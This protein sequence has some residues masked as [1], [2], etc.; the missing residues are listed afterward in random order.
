MRGSPSGSRASS[1]RVRSQTSPTSSYYRQNTDP[2]GKPYFNKY[3]HPTINGQTPQEKREEMHNKSLRNLANSRNL[4]EQQLE[5]YQQTFLEQQQQNLRDFN[6]QIMKEI[7]DDNAANVNGAEFDRSESLSSL[8]SL[9]EGSHDT[10][11]ESCDLD[12]FMNQKQGN[13]SG[14]QG[15][16]NVSFADSERDSVRTAAPAH[17][18]AVPSTV[19][20][21]TPKNIDSFNAQIQTAVTNTVKSDEQK[22]QFYLQRQREIQE[23]LHEQKLQQQR[24][25]QDLQQKVLEQ[26]RKQQ[27][28]LQQ[29]YEKQQQEQLEK[30]RQVQLQPQQENSNDTGK[31]NYR[32]KAQMKAW[33]TPSPHPPTPASVVQTTAHVTHASPYSGK[34]THTNMTVPIYD[35]PLTNTESV[36]SSKPSVSAGASSVVTCTNNNAQTSHSRTEGYVQPEIKQSEHSVVGAQERNLSFLEAVTNDLSMKQESHSVSKTSNITSVSST[37]VKTAPVVATVTSR[38]VQQ[39][40]QSAATT[41]TATAIKATSSSPATV[42]ANKPPVNPSYYV[43]SYSTA[44]ANRQQLQQQVPNGTS[45]RLPTESK[46]STVVTNTMRMNGG[47]PTPWGTPTGNLDHPAVMLTPDMALNGDD[48]ADTDSVS[49]IC[50]EKEPETKGLSLFTF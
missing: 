29:H 37:P 9:E 35:K 30:Q 34:N 20:N 16:K 45:G 24:D 25:Q 44:Y 6:N 12:N 50:E 3:A 13:N 48:T 39:Q 8:D 5:T 31:E 40:Q 23:Q 14:V 2:L 26:Q 18:T 33:A 28:L 47:M 38:P 22:Q 43:N 49:T 1:A 32:P 7:Q 19:Y 42:V 11:R 27:L 4:F 46:A 15:T 36:V 21:N 41:A 10:L 17:T